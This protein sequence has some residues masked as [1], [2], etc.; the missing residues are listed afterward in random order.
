MKNN[1]ILKELATPFPKD[2]VKVKPGKGNASYVTHGVVRQRLLM[3][4]GFYSWVIDREIFDQD[5]KLTGCVG[6]LTV[7]MPGDLDLISVQ[8]AGDVEHD[9]GSNGSNLKHAES[10]AFKRAAMNLGLGLHLWCENEYFLYNKITDEQS[11]EQA[12]SN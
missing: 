11:K 4:C 12:A 1:K 10:D 8:G 7:R 2:Y 6:T 9:Q 3:I 5:G